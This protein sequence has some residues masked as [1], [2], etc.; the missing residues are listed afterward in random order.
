MIQNYFSHFLSKISLRFENIY[1]FS[2]S[3]Q[4]EK[5]QV[6]REIV[7]CIS[8]LGCLANYNFILV[9]DYTLF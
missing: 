6:L 3:K 2:G 1:F 8:Y 9:V 7:N 5:K 4:P